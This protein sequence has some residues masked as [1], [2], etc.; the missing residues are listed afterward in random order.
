[1]F[2]DFTLTETPDAI[3]IV[4][5]DGEKVASTGYSVSGKVVTFTTAPK[6]DAKIVIRY[7]KS[8]T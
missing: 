1:M 5:I 2:S 7:T 6:D 4:T 3:K 8:T